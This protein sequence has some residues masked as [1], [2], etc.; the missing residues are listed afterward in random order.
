[1]GGGRK[2]GGQRHMCAE[3]YVAENQGKGGG[4][5]ERGSVVFCFKQRHCLCPELKAG[6]PKGDK[7]I[8][9][10]TFLLI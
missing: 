2:G 5:R 9:R 3:F 4:E 7:D 10:K 6:E 1:V 8:A